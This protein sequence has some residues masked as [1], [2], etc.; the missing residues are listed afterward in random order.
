MNSH[1]LSSQQVTQI[2]GIT[3]RQLSYWRDTALF[4]PTDTTIGGHARFSFQDTVTIKTIATLL[5]SGVSTQRIRVCIEKLKQLLPTIK[6]PL[7]ELSIVVSGE[8]LLVFH[9]GCAFEVLSGQER[10]IDIE[11]LNDDI[12]EEINGY[13]NYQNDLFIEVKEPLG[14]DYPLSVRVN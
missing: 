7:S 3:Q 4:S 2:T 10:I 5:K 12:L 6:Y 9:Q 11:K 8:T 13:K 14:K 1:G